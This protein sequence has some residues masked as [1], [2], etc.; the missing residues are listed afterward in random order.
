MTTE[1]SENNRI[2]TLTIASSGTVSTSKQIDN[3]VPVG[4]IFPS[5]WTPAD[6]S[7][8]VSLDGASWKTLPAGI[9]TFTGVVDLFQPLDAAS[10]LGV[11]HI[12]LVATVAQAAQRDLKVIYHAP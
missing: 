2:D 11:R 12:R 4:I 6:L 9:G 8:Q 10:F 5:A 7:I 3:W 1:Y